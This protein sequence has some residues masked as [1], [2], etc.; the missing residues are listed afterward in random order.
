MVGNT[1]CTHPPNRLVKSIA[2][3]LENELSSPVKTKLRPDRQSGAAAFGTDFEPGAEGPASLAAFIAAQLERSRS[4]DTSRVR[5]KRHSLGLLRR[6]RLVLLLIRLFQLPLSCCLCLCINLHI[7]LYF[8]LLF[9]LGF[10]RVGRRF[11]LRFGF[12]LRRGLHFWSG[13]RGCLRSSFRS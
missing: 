10:R 6:W 11:W 12:L 7:R 13:R 9:R 5:E 1:H 4:M 8:R 2:S 3:S